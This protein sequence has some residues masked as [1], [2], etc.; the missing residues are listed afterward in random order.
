METACKIRAYHF[1]IIM[2]M[3]NKTYNVICKYNSTPSPWLYIINVTKDF[4]K[5]FV[6]R[7][8][9]CYLCN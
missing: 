3:L 7:N 9:L 1:P 2:I 8:I 4:I 5:A 6:I